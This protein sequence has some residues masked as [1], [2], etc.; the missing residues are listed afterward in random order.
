MGF[1]QVGSIIGFHT[2]TI[3]SNFNSFQSPAILK[4]DK[5]RA[6]SKNFALKV[7]IKTAVRL[8]NTLE[9]NKERLSTSS[10][11]SREEIVAI[12]NQTNLFA[13]WTLVESSIYRS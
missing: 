2:T 8:S 6:T 13:N 7:I 11:S 4:I 12:Q 5:V 10:F 9:A 1:G 3:I